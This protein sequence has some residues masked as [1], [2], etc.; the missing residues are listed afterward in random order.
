[1]A[2]EVQ[3][4]ADI[5]EFWHAFHGIGQYFGA[6]RN[7]ERME[8]FLQYLPLERMLAAREDGTIVGGAASF[9][10]ELTIPGGTAPCAGVSVVG[11]Y[12]THR[13][14]GVLREMMRA[15]LEDVRER[16]EP[17]AALWASEEPIYGRFGYGMA[18]LQ[19]EIRLARERT[20]FAQPFERRGRVRLHEGE[21]ALETLPPIYDRVCRQTPGMFSRTRAWWEHRWIQD[22]ADRRDGAGPRRYAVLEI[23]GVFEGYAMY[24]HKAGWDEGASAGVLRVLE[25]VAATPE[26]TRELWRYLLDIDWV[27]TIEAYFLPIDH[28][29]FLLLAEPR[30]MRMR[31]GDGLWVRLV[32]VGEALS[33]RSYAD[34]GS[35]VFEVADA[36]CPW[37]EGRWKLESGRAARSEDEPA[38]RCDVGALGSVYLGGF[39]FAELQQ[40]FRIEELREGAVARA[41]ALF[42]T[43]RAPWCP[44]IF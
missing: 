14:R 7:P 22:P 18:S 23:D 21:E 42:R 38:I 44:E 15:Q 37:N 13:R 19:G 12:P 2:I 34:D 25:A 17:L 26:A 5:D 16:R 40:A 36:F 8:R 35:V 1:M 11:V 10:F 4:C 29:L 28:P 20:A 33:A 6:E 27:A 32:D 3:P 41:D 30:R 43:D 9:P 24:R 31:V 39:T